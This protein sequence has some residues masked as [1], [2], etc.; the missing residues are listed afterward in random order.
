MAKISRHISTIPGDN[1]WKM[2]NLIFP[3]IR[4]MLS[5]NRMEKLKKRFICDNQPP[6][7]LITRF[8]CPCSDSCLTLT[9]GTCGF[10]LSNIWHFF[11]QKTSDEKLILKAI[12][13]QNQ[14]AIFRAQIKRHHR[15]KVKLLL[16][17]FFFFLRINWATLVPTAGCAWF[18]FGSPI[19][20]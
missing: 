12:I 15:T 10:Q 9:C 4:P 16:L 1:V 8:T 2:F 7:P 18:I 19:A 13:L 3:P 14:S 11:L 6:S 17:F 5:L 20:V